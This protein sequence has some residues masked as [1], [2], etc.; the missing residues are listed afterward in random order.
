MRLLKNNRHLSRL[1]GF[2]LHPLVLPL[3]VFALLFYGNYT[4]WNR[5]NNL[6][7]DFARSQSL[8]VAQQAGARIRLILTERKNDLSQLVTGWQIR[9]SRERIRRFYQEAEKM[10]V[11]EPIYHLINFID[12]GSVVRASAPKGKRP[13][14]SRMD[15]T[16]LP[17]RKQL[18]QSAFQA[19]APICSPPLRLTTGKQGLIIWI[20]FRDNTGGAQWLLAGAIHTDAIIQRALEPINRRQFGVKI[21]MDTTQLYVSDTAAYAEDSGKLQAAAHYS[22]MV[23]GQNWNIC[24]YPRAHAYVDNLVKQNSRMFA[25]GNGFSL[26]TGVLISLT[27]VGLRRNRKSLSLVAASEERFRGLSTAAPI[28]IFLADPRGMTTYSN[29]AWQAISGLSA[30]QS[31]DLGFLRAL[32]PHDKELLK[33]GW[34]AAVQSQSSFEAEPRLMR[35]DG[36]ERWVFVR[37]TPMKGMRGEVLGFVGAILDITENKNAH[38]LLRESEEKFRTLVEMFPHS[39]SIFQDNKVVFA[40]EATK[41][42]FGMSSASAM[43][44]KDIFQVVAESEKERLREYAEKRARGEYAPQRYETVLVR[45]DGTEFPA[46]IIVRTI[47]YRGRHAE[48]VIAADITERKAAE[49]AIRQS[50][51]NLAVTLNSIGDAVI[52][53][54]KAG[55]VVRMNPVAEQLTGW[56]INEA[57]G[58]PL[59]TVF[60]V[61]NAFS[62]R[63]V[64][65][66]VTKV[67]REGKIVGLANHSILIH[68]DGIERQI[69][70]SGAPIRNRNGDVIGVVLVFHDVTEQYRL[71][72]QLRQAQKMEVVGRLA[73]GI[74][75]D[76]NNLLSPIL[77]YADMALMAIDKGSEL[78]EDIREI[79]SAGERARSLVGQ[80]L[81]FSRKQIL[82]MKPIDIVQ[83]ISSLHKML[84]RI[85]GEDIQVDIVASPEPVIVL[86]DTQQL[87][88]II[89]NLAV[90]ARDAMPEGGY[91]T[92]E[93][94]RTMLD[95]AFVGAHEGLTPG[96]F[97]LVTVRDTGQGMTREVAQHIFEPFFTTKARG[98]G[99][100][101]GLATV[102]GIIKQHQ[103]GIWVS[104]ETGKGATFSIYLPL[105]E[106]EASKT[107]N[108]AGPGGDDLKGD[109]TILLVEDEAVVRTSA[110]RILQRFGYKVLE[111]NCAARALE[112]ARTHEGTIDLLLTDVIMP[113]MNGRQ[114]HD[115]LSTIRPEISVL[116]MSGYTDSVIAAHG[117]L[118]Q[119]IQ[120]LQKPFTMH[121]LAR[122][123]KQ[124]LASV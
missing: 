122:K 85:I 73:G 83:A 9:D 44:Q 8:N 15:L 35:P 74:A 24:A 106:R 102:Y 25:L 82:E 7:A 17:G 103:G 31:R 21:S 68:R 78:F 51:E 70:D 14:L 16:A 96:E 1:P 88:Q 50:E 3:I 69:A 30:E 43:L 4:L 46:E 11:H 100:G 94:S 42:M 56:T 113:D 48:Q 54:D 79:Q 87:E 36:Q 112:V 34:A 66:P 92:I 99:T 26:L 47:T 107:H 12:S 95:E 61:V 5:A 22:S 81:A 72:E 76:F 45:D 64:E 116:Y 90:N 59:E 124:I 13:E 108:I 84:T 75:H 58:A 111:A 33:E 63:T 101:L 105:A 20:P 98:E 89:L 37:A 39:I 57:R 28:G 53:T 19:T 38:L 29:P 97:A 110:M 91:L 115:Q 71:E 117:V 77:G 18:H 27:L 114:L 109:G 93:I 65:S 55:K 80:L 62:R 120:F 23:L 121:G 123:V 86:A 52:A 60:I 2:F 104:S 49:E 6:A 41:R 67:L 32:H 119:G 118:E 40:N 10:A